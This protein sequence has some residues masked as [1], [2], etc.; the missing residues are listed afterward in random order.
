MRAKGVG[1]KTGVTVIE[2]AVL[3][4]AM[5]AALVA[6]QTPLRRAISGRWRQAADVFGDGRQ[7]EPQ[8]AR[9]TVVYEY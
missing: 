6:M 1:Y 9:A 7:Y 4:A 8:G 2:Y 3:L 5:V